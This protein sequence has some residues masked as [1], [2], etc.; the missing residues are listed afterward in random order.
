MKSDRNIIATYM[1]DGK[2]TQ[3]RSLKDKT[4][5]FGMVSDGLA[6]AQVVT[7]FKE[8]VVSYH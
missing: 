5:I 4:R 2:G 1:G 3:G 6:Y 7:M 8:N